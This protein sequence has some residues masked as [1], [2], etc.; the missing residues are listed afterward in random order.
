MK[1]KQF[2]NKITGE[3]VTQVPLSHFSDYEEVKEDRNSVPLAIQDI[4]KADKI[5]KKRHRYSCGLV[6]E[7][8]KAAIGCGDLFFESPDGQ[9]GELYSELRNLGYS[10]GRF[11]A[12]YDWKISKNG[13]QISYCEGDIYV[14]NL[15][16][17]K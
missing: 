8:E 9:N 12:G 4:I 13:I 5:I 17:T 6:S 3:I 14:K 16:E 2:K 1:S 7:V 15:N 10:M 11:N